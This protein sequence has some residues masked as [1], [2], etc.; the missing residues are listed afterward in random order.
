MRFTRIRA[1]DSVGLGGAATGTGPPAPED[2][3]LE[4]PGR[5]ANGM[6]WPRHHSEFRWAQK[7]YRLCGAA[8]SLYRAKLLEGRLPCYAA[9]TRMLQDS[10]WIAGH[11]LPHLKEYSHGGF[12]K[13]G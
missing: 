6:L 4:F 8:C 9:L 1:D 12:V 13:F 10:L 2:P 3:L 11:P 7:V 5:L